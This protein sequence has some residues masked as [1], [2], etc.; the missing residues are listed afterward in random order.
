MKPVLYS[1]GIS[2]AY[3]THN[4]LYLLAVSRTNSNAMAALYFLHRLVG[5][6]KHY[7]EARSCI[8][9]PAAPLKRRC[10]CWTKNH[11]ETIL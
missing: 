9:D 8:F 10:R 11:Y 3:V 6:F 5:V 2:Y 4:N 1:E 7:V